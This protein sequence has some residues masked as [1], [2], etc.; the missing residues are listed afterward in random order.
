MQS[1]YKWIWRKSHWIF[2]SLE[3]THFHIIAS[4]HFDRTLVTDQ[5]YGRAVIVG[6][7]KETKA[8][9]ASFARYETIVTLIRAIAIVASTARPIAG[10]NGTHR[11]RSNGSGRFVE[12]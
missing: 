10:R 12:M 6:S 2:R 5:T 9:P 8:F 3:L 7:T 1:L 11:F 4:A